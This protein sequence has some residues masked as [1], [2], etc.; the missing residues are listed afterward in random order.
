MARMT[1]ALGSFRLIL[2]TATVGTFASLSG[3]YN[4][5]PIH[6]IYGD[7]SG[8]QSS[9]AGGST[10]TGGNDAATGGESAGVGGAAATGGNG[11]GG[12][13]N[14]HCT[15]DEECTNGG[16][17]DLTTGVC[18]DPEGSGGNEGTGGDEGG[19]GGAEGSGGSNGEFVSLIT[20]GDF[21]SGLDGWHGG[22]D[23]LDEEVEGEGCVRWNSTI[24]WDGDA[25]GLELE[26]GAY[27]LSVSMR[28]VDSGETSINVEVKVALAIDPYDPV[29]LSERLENLGNSDGTQNF[30][31]SVDSTTANVGLAFFVDLGQDED[32][33]FCIDDVVLEKTN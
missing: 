6:L 23:N 3:C 19:S 33:E 18:T 10:A 4:D 21:S 31:F 13:L 26:A 1:R 25:N 9:A 20:N 24:G 7:A 12:E 11:L 14:T 29:F 22:E 17:C 2:L 5:A 15:M 28:T 16:S 27:A 30:T 8:G 32:D